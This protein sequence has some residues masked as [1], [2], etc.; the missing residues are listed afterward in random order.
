MSRRPF[1]LAVVGGSA[2]GKT[3]LAHAL[4]DHFSGHDAYVIPEDDYYVDAGHQPGFIASD[5]NFDEPAA[6]DHALLAS[7]LAA[8][9]EGQPV[10]A[11]QYD[12]TTHC[13]RT[14]TIERAP[15]GVLIV[16]GL[17][18]LASPELAA[19]FDLTIFVD[20]CDTTRLTR[21]IQRDVA[22]RGRSEAF[23]KQQF[24]EIVRPMHALHVE[25]QREA[26]DLVVEN[27]GAPDFDALARPVVDRIGLREASR[28]KV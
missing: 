7:H 1:L 14:Q 20:A 5:F 2:S 3:R 12:F 28:Q 19:Q 21:R 6:K 22:E 9:R 26:A 24:D 11:P 4:A 16:E 15:A 13:R 17:H 23:V 25:P 18:L 10:E 8:L 27:M